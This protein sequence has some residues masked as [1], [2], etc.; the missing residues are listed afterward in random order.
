VVINFGILTSLAIRL[1]AKNK[2]YY[3]TTTTKNGEWCAGY[4]EYQNM[5]RQ[6]GGQK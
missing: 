5:R 6:K 3:D 1:L 2:K 4:F